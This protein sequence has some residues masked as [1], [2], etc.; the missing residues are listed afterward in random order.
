MMD[1]LHSGA[2]ANLTAVTF[3]RSRNT[4]G[5]R[6]HIKQAQLTGSNHSTKENGTMTVREHE[7]FDYPITVHV[8]LVEK[9]NGRPVL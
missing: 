9:F 1:M 3:D 8:A 7:R 4:G 6:I 2:T 5:K